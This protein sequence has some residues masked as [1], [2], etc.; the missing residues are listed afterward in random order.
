MYAAI[1]IILWGLLIAFTLGW[2]LLT[3]PPAP[4]P[5]GVD[6]YAAEVAAFRQQ[7]HDWDRP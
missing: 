4:Q 6:P 1:L 3:M 5:A 7:I 2:L